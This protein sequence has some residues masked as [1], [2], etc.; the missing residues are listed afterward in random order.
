MGT[1]SYS[2]MQPFT[3]CAYVKK[4]MAEYTVKLLLLFTVF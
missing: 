1:L 2:P 3:L 4:V